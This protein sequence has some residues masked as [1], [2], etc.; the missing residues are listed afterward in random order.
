M[1]SLFGHRV[2]PQFDLA[3]EQRKNRVGWVLIGATVASLIYLSSG[4]PF[5]TEVF[6]VCF[7]T[8]LGYGATFYARWRKDLG[9]AWMRKTILASI[10]VHV[11]YLV[12]IFWSDVAFPSIMTRAIAFVPV[13]SV[14]FV[15]E[16]C[17]FEGILR[18]FKPSNRTDE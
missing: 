1:S 11:L 5:A 12:G 13:L 2:D 8:I 18:H 14:G 10:P 9:K 4:L 15:V 7:A 16:A 3:E 6:Q 17:S